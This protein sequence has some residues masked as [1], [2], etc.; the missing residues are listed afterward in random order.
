ME[1]LY[2]RAMLVEARW[3]GY[4]PEPFLCTVE[5]RWSLIPELTVEAVTGEYCGT[6][7]PGLQLRGGMATEKG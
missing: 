2:S 7:L 1:W 4:I 6:I 3:N 5:A